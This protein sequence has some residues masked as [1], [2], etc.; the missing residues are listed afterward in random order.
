MKKTKFYTEDE[1]LDRVIG[2]KGTSDRDAYEEENEFISYG[3][4]DT[5]GTT[6]QKSDSRTVRRTDRS[7]AGTSLKD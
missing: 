6:V 1:A 4:I 5:A 2:I 3:R 7:E